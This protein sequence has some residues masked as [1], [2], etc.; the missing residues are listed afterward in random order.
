MTNS[1]A[2]LPP[3]RPEN[4]SQGVSIQSHPEETGLQIIDS[5][6]RHRYSLAT[7]EPVSPSPVSTD[8]LIFPVDTAVSLATESITLPSVV[9]VYVRDESGS[10]LAEAE[11]F[12][13]E[14]FSTGTYSIELCAPI[15]LYLRVEGPV[16]VS[17]DMEHTQ[18]EFG[19][20]TRVVVGARS[21]HDHPA[22]TITTTTDPEDVMTAVSHFGSA[23]K[24]TSPERSYPT[25]RGH[26]PTVELGDELD[27]PEEVEP[28]ET[29]I[30]IEIPPENRSI[31]IA[32]PLAYYLGAQLVPG[33]TPRLVT[34]TGFEYALD[35]PLG[36]E[37][38]VAQ[39]LK[40][41]FF[42]DCVTRTEGFYKVDLHEREAIEDEVDLDFEALYETSLSTQLE[43]YLSVPFSVLEPFLPEWK[44]TTHVEPRADSVETL[45]FVVDDLAVIRVPEV[46]AIQSSEVE[47]AAVGEFLRDGE[48]T[49]S[50][51]NDALSQSSYIQPESAPSLEQTW[52]GNGTPVGANKATTEAFEHHLS[53]APTDGAID[54][55]VVCN[56]DEMQ[57]EWD[58]IEEGYGSRADLPFEVTFH[59]NL[60][61]EELRNVLASSSDFLHYVGHIDEAGFQCADGKLDATT[62]ESVGV[63]AFFLNAC[64]SYHQGMQLIEAGSIGGV[65]TLSDI[66]NSGAIRIG[67]AMAR[68]LNSGFPLQAALDI[69]QDESII[70]NQY[71]VVG[72]SGLAIAQAEGGTPFVYEV[73]PVGDEFEVGIRTY[74]TAE[75]G[76]G[77]LVM[78]HIED[79]DCH[80]LSAG[81]IS[82]IR[83]SG[84]ELQQVLS[85][86]DL[87][88]KVDGQLYWSTQVTVGQLLGTA[89]C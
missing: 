43:A 49:R 71:I 69:A 42:L 32:A 25:L 80:F 64:Q 5:I 41:V 12:A 17:S 50:A 78:P 59:R 74:P 1:G 20:S 48:L 16:T 81:S 28:P 3:H 36:F 75:R 21:H 4:P 58:A 56:D 76:M 45:P 30:Q 62:L 11:H 67:S 47:Q 83:L 86:E 88:V 61:T 23:L 65:V 2:E 84:P 19:P 8:E 38:E 40:Q 27:I 55:T 85:L 35:S 29:G 44:L 13:Y 79:I 14:E 87:P 31:F 51:S 52:I 26:P 73:T 6:E 33:G 89:R 57:A 7:A 34:D 10:M 82:E 70:G 68:L 63:D 15:K 24:T 77:S 60:T 39:V 53:R 54:I 66:I 9:A 22:A 46:E 72:D 18:L 37:T